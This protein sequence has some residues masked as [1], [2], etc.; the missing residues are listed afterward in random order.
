MM[1]SKLAKMCGTP[2]NV[3]TGANGPDSGTKAA[4]REKVN[5]SMTKGRFLPDAKAG[6]FGVKGVGK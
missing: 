5:S 4:G 1:N 3:S 2:H 6:T